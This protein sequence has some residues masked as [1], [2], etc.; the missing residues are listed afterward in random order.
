MCGRF[1]RHSPRADAAAIGDVLGDHDGSF[2]TAPTNRV[3]TVR[4]NA[5]SDERTLDDLHWGLIPHFA[6]DKKIAWKTI[7]ARAET[8]EKMP[9]YR[10]A[11]AKRRCLIVADGFYE[12]LTI[13]K[14]KQPF[15]IAMKSRKPFGIAGLWENWQEP[16]NGEWLRSCSII[17]TTANSLVGHIHDRMPVILDP[18]DYP[19]WLGEQPA[20]PEELKALLKPYDPAAMVIWPVSP[21]INKPGN[22]NDPSVLEPVMPSDLPAMPGV[23]TSA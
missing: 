4:F 16:A 12:W 2:N 9:S 11:F 8:V 18:S 19:Q 15:A 23:L 5:K 6:N 21:A 7:N 10:G 20:T 13:G 14:R 17:T 22:A 3:L 1:F